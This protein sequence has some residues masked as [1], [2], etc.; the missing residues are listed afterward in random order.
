MNKHVRLVEEQAEG[1][2][3]P[4]MVP[5]SKIRRY[6]G[7]PRRHFNKAE[8]SELADDMGKNG[9]ETP[10]S[11]C[12]DSDDPDGFVLIG[13]ER[14]WR[15]FGVIAERT[16]T[17]PMLKCFVDTINDERHH[18]RKAFRDNVRRKDLIP[19]DEAEAYKR[20]YDESVE[21]NHREK[22]LEVVRE[23]GKGSKHVENYLCVALLDAKVKALMDPELLEKQLTPIVAI[24]IA[25]SAQDP[26]LQLE[27]ARAIIDGGLDLGQSR[28]LI[29][30]KTGRQA[31]GLSGRERRAS[32]EYAEFMLFLGRIQYRTGRMSAR[33]VESFFKGR[34][35]E[36]GDRQKAA[37]ILDGIIETLESLRNRVGGAKDAE[38]LAAT[39]RPAPTLPAPK[40][41]AQEP[42]PKPPVMQDAKAGAAS[43]LAKRAEGDLAPAPA[44]AVHIP[45]PKVELKPASHYAPPR[46]PSGPMARKVVQAP[47]VMGRTDKEKTV[48]YE[49][50]NGR[51]VTDK[52]SRVRYLEIWD[53]KQFKFQIEG[54]D[55]PDWMPSREEAA[56]IEDWNKFCQ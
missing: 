32:D 47:S 6:E 36:D 50:S 19:V 48:T 1:A 2:G 28:E 55:R 8:I 49:G 41:A 14:R 52:V 25:K 24:D 34:P 42:A 37:L 11:V 51:L 43:F 30:E 38:A 7:Q 29:R 56:K 54:K 10:V 22:V 17:D 12:R 4:L 18:F 5:L 27:L 3:T 44:R 46:P 9:Q 31:Y 39:S 13:G 40:P 45:E 26:E 35:Q 16:N 33:H 23:S 53:S 20:I 15:A 21:D